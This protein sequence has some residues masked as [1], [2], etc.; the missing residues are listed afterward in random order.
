MSSTVLP[1]RVLLTGLGSLVIGEPAIVRV[2]SLMP[3]KVVDWTSLAPSVH[4]QHY[5]GFIERLGYRMMDHVL[6]TG[7]TPEQASRFYGG[8]SENQ[9]RSMVAYARRHGFLAP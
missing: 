5:A 3:V 9:M 2:S 8:M 6:K 4:E 7:W 1:R